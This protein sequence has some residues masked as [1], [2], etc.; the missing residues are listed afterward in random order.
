MSDTPE[1]DNEGADDNETKP[2]RPVDKTVDYTRVK[3]I[4]DL[5]YTITRASDAGQAPKKHP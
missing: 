2:E 3:T 5:G 4:K 1:R